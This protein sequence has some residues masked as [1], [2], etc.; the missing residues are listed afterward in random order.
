MHPQSFQ[1]HKVFN[2]PLAIMSE[3]NTSELMGVYNPLLS[4]MET[5]FHSSEKQSIKVSRDNFYQT[6][7]NIFLLLK[8]ED[9]NKKIVKEEC[10]PP[11][12]PLPLKN[13]L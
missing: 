5:T 10:T 12:N 3:K 11:I 13:T 6:D 2:L 8:S 9:R 1:V 4:A 7:K